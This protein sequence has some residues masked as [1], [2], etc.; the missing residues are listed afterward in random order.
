[1]RNLYTFVDDLPVLRE[2]QVTAGYFG[3]DYDFRGTN[4]AVY[5]ATYLYR[6]GPECAS[7]ISDSGM[8]CSSPVSSGTIAQYVSGCGI[9]IHNVFNP[10]PFFGDMTRWFRA[11]QEQEPGKFRGCNSAWTRAVGELMREAMAFGYD[12]YINT[13]T[14]WLD[15]CLM[16]EANPPH[17][18]RVAGGPDYCTVKRQV[19][20]TEERGVRENDGHGICMWGRYMAWHWLGRPRQWNEQHFAATAAAVDWIRWQLDTDT[21]FPGKRQDVLYTESECAHGDYEIYSSFNCLHGIK[22][23][24]RMA[25]QLGKK[26][27]VGKWQALYARLRQGILD[28]LVDQS[29]FG[30]IWHTYPNTDW[31]DH[32]HKLVPIHLATE[33]D[34]YTPLQDYAAGDE[35]D[36]KYLEISRNTY[37]YLM[38]EKNYNCLRMYG[39]G[40]GMM[41][42]AALLLDEMG[43]AEQFLN[44]LVDHAYLPKF[45]GWA[46]P[47]GI[48]LHR[49]G[50][51]YLPVNGYMGQDAHAADSTKAV[52]LLL[53][54]DDNK[55]ENLRLV[56]RFPASWMR[57]SIAR[58]PVLTGACRQKMDYE[59]SRNETSQEFAFRFDQ[60]PV[61]FSLRLGPLPAGKQVVKA[62]L[63]GKEISFQA[64]H[65]GDSNWVWLQGIAGQSGKLRIDMQNAPLAGNVQ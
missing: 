41:T 23:S 39:Y 12:K 21:L 6:N 8:G 2:P 5:A 33:G 11:Y 17:W 46:S 43:D 15:R 59:Y 3:P 24:I 27:E 53:G 1:M 32:A 31:Q 34:T 20:D 36:R 55:P 37:R 16:T 47:E 48:I 51:Y 4:E 14:D 65:S 56:P 45:S 25:Q 44:M 30:P 26:E 7:F 58:F 64:Q 19:G 62:T 40:Q 42:Q 57:M 35:V 28:N 29:E 60:R 52:R 22:L 50:K 13:Y 54:V 63:A 9:R 18:N 10:A 61:V 49:S 38:K